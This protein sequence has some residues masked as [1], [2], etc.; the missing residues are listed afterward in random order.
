M[1]RDGGE[2]PGTRLTVDGGPGWQG[3]HPTRAPHL[4]SNPTTPCGFGTFPT[5]KRSIGSSASTTA[6]GPEHN[7]DNIMLAHSLRPH[8]MEGHM[9]LYKSVLHHSDNALPT[10]FLE[11]MGT[12][13]SHLN[14]CTSC[15]EHHFSGMRRL[16]GDDRRGSQMRAAL[17]HGAYEPLCS[18]SEA[19][20]LEYAHALTVA[21][22]EQ[23]AVRRPFDVLRASGLDDGKI[24]EINQVVANFGYANRVVI[25]L[26]VTTD[27]DIH[28]T[29]AR[30]CRRQQ[31]LV[32]SLVRPRTPA[33]IC[34]ARAS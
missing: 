2:N 27:G 13:V 17:E 33:A 20:A 10:W 22:H 15:V 7:V 5:I 12:L 30:Q 6:S 1:G 8:S 18:A 4:T 16:L 23:D 34:R 9:A 19:R 28:G 31:R 29:V 32:T 25:G 24:L 11:A 3:P 21:V 26:G 14:R